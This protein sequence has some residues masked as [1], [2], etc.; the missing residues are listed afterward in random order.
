MITLGY[1]FTLINYVFFCGSRFLV[2]KKNIL[3]MDLVAKIFTVMGLYCL[4][5]LSGA[6][7]FGIT[8]FLLIAAN[9]K[10]RQNKK[11]GA[12]FVIFQ[13]LY[14]LTMILQY[15]GLSSVLICA[16]CS[17]NL[18]CVWFLAPQNMRL[19]GGYNSILFLLY[20]ISIKNWAGLV[21]IFVIISNFAAYFKYKKQPSADK[22]A[23]R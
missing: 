8:F 14:L 18:V 4:N 2:N 5:S 16:S 6:F 15:E 1:I 3:L 21:E 9:I 11:W 7:S 19:V 13:A 20:Q 23:S 17:L 22:K 10:E 12:G